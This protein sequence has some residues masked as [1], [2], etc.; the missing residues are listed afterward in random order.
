[1]DNGKETEL[2]KTSDYCKH[3][4]SSN[5]SSP[6]ILVLFNRQTGK[7]YRVLESDSEIDLIL[8]GKDHTSK[9]R[10]SMVFSKTSGDVTFYYDGHTRK[11]TTE[12]LGNIEKYCPG[13]LAC[14]NKD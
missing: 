8:W 12:E 5:I 10:D 14:V 11:E 1:M 13:L 3:E 6:Y 2:S 7:I 9:T 4:I